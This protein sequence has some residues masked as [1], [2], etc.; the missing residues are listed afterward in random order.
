MLSGQLLAY[1]EAISGLVGSVLWFRSTVAV[2]NYKPVRIGKNGP[3]ASSITAVQPDGKEIDIIA[4]AALQTKWNLWAGL[5]TG[6]AVF[7][8]AVSTFSYS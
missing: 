3:I 6:V 5:F 4:T 7:L 2:V 1:G 8:Q